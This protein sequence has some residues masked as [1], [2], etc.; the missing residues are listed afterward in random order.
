MSSKLYVRYDNS[1]ILP[2]TSDI[3]Y[4]S[5]VIGV[6]MSEFDVYLQFLDA[7]KQPVTPTAGTVNVYGQPFEG[8]LLEAAGSPVNAV[9]ISVGVSNYTPPTISGLAELITVKFTGIKGAN[10]V[11]ICIYRKD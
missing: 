3:S 6:G 4:D 5:P 10:F 8:M 2:V 7:S 11:K 1:Y 9:D